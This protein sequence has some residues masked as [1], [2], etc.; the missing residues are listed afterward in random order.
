VASRNGDF[1]YDAG[2]K[3]MGKDQHGK[4]RLADMWCNAK[5]DMIKNQSN[6]DLSMHQI[7][8]LTDAGEEWCIML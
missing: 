7:V 8:R 3:M 6:G 4:R 5:D 2:K 1:A